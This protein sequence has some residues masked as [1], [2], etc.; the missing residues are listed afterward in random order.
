VFN[1]NGA[2]IDTLTN[3]PASWGYFGVSMAA[4]GSSQVLIGASYGGSGAGAAYLFS[5]EDPTPEAPRLSVRLTPSNAMVVSWPSPSTGYG[6]QQNTDTISSVNWSNV[7]TGI[8][9]DGTNKALLV[10]PSRGSRFYR[11][12]KP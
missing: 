9:D 7:T 11:L 2:R 3:P 12:F 4:I 5:A 6:L 1:T 10:N 8:L